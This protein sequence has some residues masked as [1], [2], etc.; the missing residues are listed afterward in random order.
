MGRSRPFNRAN[1]NA[2]VDRDNAVLVGEQW[3]DVEV[4]DFRDIGGLL[5][6]FDEHQRDR[7]H[8]RGRDVAVVG[9]QLRNARTADEFARQL[10]IERRQRQ[11]GVARLRPKP[12]RR[13]AGKDGSAQPC[14]ELT[15]LTPSGWE[16]LARCNLTQLY[17]EKSG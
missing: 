8:I 13:R 10:K 6:D 16:P 7:R 15:S 2:R 17:R 12:R 14:P 5:L 11:R 4:A 9:E 1:R 3:I